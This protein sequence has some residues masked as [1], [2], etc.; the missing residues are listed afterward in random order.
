ML[1]L[2]GETA[3]HV[4]CEKGLSAL[5]RKLL[6][7]GANPNIATAL[8]DSVLAGDEVVSRSYRMTPL[9]SAILNQQDAAVKTILE[10]NSK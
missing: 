2:Q 6:E 5:I 1:Y 9:L 10:Y 7:C 3:L 4:A 8:P